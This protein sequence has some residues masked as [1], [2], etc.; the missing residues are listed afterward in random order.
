MKKWI[1]FLMLLAMSFNG[2]IYAQTNK[3]SSSNQVGMG[4]YN[5]YQSSVKWGIAVGGIGVASAAFATII[6]LAS[7]DPT[8]FPATTFAHAH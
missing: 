5:G 1:L 3:G 7:T 6:V 8:T 4:A 2:Q